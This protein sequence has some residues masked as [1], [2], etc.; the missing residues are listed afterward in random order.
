MVKKLK[1][2]QTGESSQYITKGKAM[3]TLQLN[4][5]QFHRL[6]IL[7]GIY[8]REPRKKKNLTK[9]YYHVKDI[10]YLSHEQLL[11]K[12][13]Q[14]DSWMK[15]V[16]KARAKQEPERAKTLVDN[17]PSYSLHHLVKERYPTFADALKDLDD[18]LSMVC[19]FASCPSNKDL[20]ISVDMIRASEKLWHEF[21]IY[22]MGARTL[23]KAFLSIKGIYYQAEIRGQPVTWLVPY[24][25]TQNLPWDVDYSIMLT[26]L[27]FY[28]TLLRFVNFRLYKDIGLE[29]PPDLSQPLDSVLSQT[30]LP[31]EVSI[32]TEFLNSPEIQQMKKA[33]D[34]RQAAQN[35]FSNLVF[36]LGRETPRYS[37]ELVI[38]AAGGKIVNEDSNLVTHQVIDRPVT[39]MRGDR[40]Y[41]QPQWIYDS[42]NFKVL[43]PI[44]PYKPGQAPPAHLSPFIDPSK[45]EYNPQRLQEILQIKGE[46]LT[47]QKTIAEDKKELGKIMM[48]K[49]IRNLYT[50][51]QFV[52]RK[53]RSFT[54]RLKMRRAEVSES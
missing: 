38:R 42:L 37:L 50:R 22:L 43:L 21:E 1:K 27:E 2:G 4:T 31:E 24:Q 40:E 51:I 6:C 18:A 11:T 20:K 19:L 7:K 14:I 12:F 36:L 10:R 48:S 41:V 25:F 30:H 15:K 32:S 26:F 17:A 46:S 35:L 29:Y 44:A 34:E 28:H 13:R 53:K 3:R 8:P 52:L 39:D 45:E 9:T 5:K 16:R 49:K 54:E 23:R 47:E 33:Q